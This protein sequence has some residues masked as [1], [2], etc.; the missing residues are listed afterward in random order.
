MGFARQL[1]SRGEQNRHLGFKGL[2]QLGDRGGE[3]SIKIGSSGRLARQPIERHDPLHV[4]PRQLLLLPNLCRQVAR[5]EADQKVEADEDDILQ[6]CN[7]KGIAWLDE[8]KI[9][10]DRTHRRRQQGRP[11]PDVNGNQ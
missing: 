2:A 1:A 4:T 7:D 6:L 10:R 11:A 5:K 3:D 9:K 8:E